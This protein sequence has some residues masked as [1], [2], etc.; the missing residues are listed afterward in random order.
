M[1]TRYS[2]T[3]DGLLLYPYNYLRS[4]STTKLYINGWFCI[5]TTTINGWYNIG[6]KHWF[7][8]SITNL[9]LEV[10]KTNRMTAIMTNGA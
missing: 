9:Q 10:E 3:Q 2:E 5:L 6:V 1:I 8:G 7:T 4:L